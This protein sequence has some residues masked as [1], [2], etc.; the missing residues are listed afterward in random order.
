MGRKKLVV[1]RI[2][3]PTGRLGTYR[4]RKDGIVKKAAELSGLCGTDV[5][6]IMFSPNGGLTSFA[7]SGSIEDVFLRYL[8]LPDASR[9]ELVEN[10]EVLRQGLEH[11]KCEAKMLEVLT[12]KQALEE[13]L[14]VLNQ[15]Q[16]EVQ[17]KIRCYNPE[18]EE[19]RSV[20]EAEVHIRF[21]SDAI[22][23]IEYLK[24]AKSSGKPA[25]ASRICQF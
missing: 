13:E 8:N 25:S 5:G 9:G 11:V 22:R 21:L 4:K 20:R 2:D 18:P 15:Q 12:K 19:T 6:L 3:N 16:T 10:Q 14:T 23:R 24:Q 7:S 1:K 17:E